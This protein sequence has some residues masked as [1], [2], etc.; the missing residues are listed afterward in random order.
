M[1]PVRRYR[2]EID[3]KVCLSLG[4]T[5]GMAPS[6]GKRE[7][8]RERTFH[9]DDGGFICTETLIEGSRVLSISDLGKSE[10]EWD[11]T[12]PSIRQIEDRRAG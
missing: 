4:F 12:A 8:T 10:R 1:S 3:P 5:V 11:L 2:T 9:G 6:G 7:G